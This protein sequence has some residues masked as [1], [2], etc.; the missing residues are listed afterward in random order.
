[1]T[2]AYSFAFRH[3]DPLVS[4]DI[5]LLLNRYL[6]GARALEGAP[7]YLFDVVLHDGTLIGQIDLRVGDTPALVTYAGQIGYGIDRPYRGHHYAAKACELI[8]T[9]ALDHGMAELWITCNP[10]NIASVR[11]C[12]RIGARFVERVSVP[13]GTELWRRGDR[14]KLRYRWG[15]ADTDMA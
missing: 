5:A 6:E 7:A 10:D 13:R 9:V 2:A 1:M 4:D 11:T 14:E 8:R 15:L 12:E 3:Y